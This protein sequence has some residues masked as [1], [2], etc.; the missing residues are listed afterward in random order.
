[1]PVNVWTYCSKNRSMR[2]FQVS[3]KLNGIVFII[4][5]LKGVLSILHYYAY[6]TGRVNL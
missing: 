5:Q 4:G 6:G 3:C 2:L 1:V